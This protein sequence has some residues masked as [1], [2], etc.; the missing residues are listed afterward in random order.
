MRATRAT[1]GIL[2]DLGLLHHTDDLSRNEPFLIPVRRKP[3]VATPYTF[4]GNDFQNFE[5][6]PWTCSDF[7]GALKAE[8]D[9]PYRESEHRRRMISVSAPGR[10]AGRASRMRVIENFSS[11][12]RGTR[13]WRLC[14][15]IRS[16]ASLY[17]TL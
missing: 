9:A 17:R 7:A 4:M 2:Q 11:M 15:K 12:R 14:G 3:F 13:E 16:R 5:C 10:M 6:R 1:F 8:F